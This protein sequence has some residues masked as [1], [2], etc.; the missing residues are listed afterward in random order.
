MA[1]AALSQAVEAPLA[2]TLPLLRPFVIVDLRPT[3]DYSIAHWPRSVHIGPSPTASVLGRLERFRGQPLVVL[4][5]RNS[6]EPCAVANALVTALFPLVS[7]LRG[8][9]D[10]LVLA[11]PDR[12]ATG[13]GDILSEKR[14]EKRK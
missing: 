12:L 2:D 3:D 14:S 9:I 11:A 4:G 5:E 8:G 13:T 10:A 1:F 6:D 7:V